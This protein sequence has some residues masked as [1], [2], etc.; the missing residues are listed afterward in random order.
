MAIPDMFNFHNLLE[1]KFKDS[2]DCRNH[3]IGWNG[4]IVEL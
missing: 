3:S 2:N 4:L 1:I